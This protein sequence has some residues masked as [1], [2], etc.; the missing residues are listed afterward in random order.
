[1]DY[2][3]RALYLIQSFSELIKYRKKQLFIYLNYLHSICLD[4][5]IFYFKVLFLF[6]WVTF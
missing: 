6:F 5:L 3:L 2:S 4:D 1:M